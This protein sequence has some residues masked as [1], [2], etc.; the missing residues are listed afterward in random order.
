MVMC[1]QDKVKSRASIPPCPED[2]G[3]RHELLDKLVVVKLNGGLGSTMGCHTIPKSALEVRNDC[4]FLDLSVRQI[5][6]LN[7]LH[8]V[9]VPII[10]MNSFKTHT[11]TTK[12]I[13]RYR[14]NNMF[15]NIVCIIISYV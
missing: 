14:Y 5:E 8:G 2:F 6:Y 15:N 3:L 7:S 12:L 9:D 4:S 1:N 13:Q 10:L 11:T